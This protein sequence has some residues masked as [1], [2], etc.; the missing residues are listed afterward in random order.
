MKIKQIKGREVLDSRGYP[1]IEAEVILKNGITGRAIVPSGASTGTREM[2]ELRDGDSRRYLG[3]GVL[4]TVD[5]VNNIINQKLTGEEIDNQAR[6]DTLLIH[7]DG[8]DKRSKLGAN[9]LLAVSLAI[10]KT[11]AH[12][13]QKPLYMSL[14][15]NNHY[16]LPVPMMNIING[17]E[18]A[19]NNIDLQE[20]MIMP[21]GAPT[22]KE[23]LR[24]G[25]EV[26]HNLK[27]ILAKKGFN[28]T[29][30]DEGG[31]AP[32]LKNNEQALSMIMQ[33]IE[34][35]GYH[36]GDDIFISID[37]ASSEFY[38]NGYY[39][40]ASEKQKLTTGD[41]INY[42]SDWVKRYPLISIEDA[43]DENDWSGWQLLTKHL[44]K[45]V[46]LVGDDLLTTNSQTLKKCINKN[47]AN[48]ILIK[49]NQIGT[50]TET[51][52]AMEIAKSANYT[53]IISHRSGETEDTTIADLA[54]ATA[55]GQIKTGSLSRSDRLAKY[56]QLLR[57][58]ESLGE[59]AVY[60][61]ASAFE[62]LA[63]NA[64]S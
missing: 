34:Q 7:L 61:G 39:F 29:V 11:R 15:S 55:C 48:S 60:A 36:A 37:V 64:R 2:L 10:A 30:G 12:L 17:G 51:L 3:K 43:L 40:L 5:G 27:N 21:M 56:N 9:A 13:E 6:L 63:L 42:L 33:A 58:E 20:F 45:K 41:M 31:F 46:Q 8:T 18:H 59:D 49:P 28:T 62:I 14:S 54:V 19:N 16:I 1:T 52:N 22:F 47:I 26:F 23:A 35:S 57:I 44:G 4:K 38:R 50:L 32:N 24:Y 53:A 25:A